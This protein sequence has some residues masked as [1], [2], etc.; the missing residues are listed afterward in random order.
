MQN[1]SA[2]ITRVENMTDEAIRRHHGPKLWL[3]TESQSARYRDWQALR[4]KIIEQY[5][6]GAFFEAFLNGTAVELPELP[7]DLKR[8]LQLSEPPIIPA[9]ASLS[10][11]FEIYARH[12]KLTGI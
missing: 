2:M 9:D 1:I 10:E 7:A 3:L 6:P 8:A 12:S 5:P 4:L 11:A